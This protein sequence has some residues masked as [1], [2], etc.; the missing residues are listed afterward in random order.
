MGSSLEVFNGTKMYIAYYPL[1]VA[2]HIS[3]RWTRPFNAAATTTITAQ[4]YNNTSI[5]IHA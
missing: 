1:K 3:I 4:P 2:N 5:F